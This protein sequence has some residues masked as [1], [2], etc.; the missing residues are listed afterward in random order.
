[1]PLVHFILIE[2]CI[3]TLVAIASLN[4]LTILFVEIIIA[5]C[6]VRRHIILLLVFSD[7]LLLAP[8]FLPPHSATAHHRHR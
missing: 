5:A 1:M 2:P 4:P 6:E 7:A 3:G 8:S